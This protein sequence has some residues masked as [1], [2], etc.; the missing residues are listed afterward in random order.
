MELSDIVSHY[1]VAHVTDLN[2][3]PFVTEV[4]PMNIAAMNLYTRYGFIKDKYLQKYYMNGSDAIR[5][6][7]FLR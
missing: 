3:L 7:L 2:D 5:L 6:K 4:S 1:F